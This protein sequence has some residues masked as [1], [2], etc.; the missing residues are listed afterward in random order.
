MPVTIGTTFWRCPICKEEMTIDGTDLATVGT[1]F[2]SDCED[3]EMESMDD[4]IPTV[5]YLDDGE[6]E[7]YVGVAL[8]TKETSIKQFKMRIAKLWHE[9][10]NAPQSLPVFNKWLEEEHGI[11][12]LKCGLIT[13][14]VSDTD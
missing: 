6:D 14:D 3:Q 9:F 7:I 8:R 5:L 11:L 12:F 10:L 4:P 13:V 2:C 1:P